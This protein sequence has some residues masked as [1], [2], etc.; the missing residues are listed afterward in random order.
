MLDSFDLTMFLKFPNLLMFMA[1]AAFAAHCIF[2]NI[3]LWDCYDSASVDEFWSMDLPTASGSGV[4]IKFKKV[5][6]RFLVLNME[7][8]KLIVDF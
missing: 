4:L 3:T 2:V 1:P 5:C 7:V 6:C 8:L